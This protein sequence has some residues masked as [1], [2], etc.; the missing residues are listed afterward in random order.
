MS[1]CNS[2]G[3]RALCEYTRGAL[4]QKRSKV[5]IEY[6]GQVRAFMTRFIKPFLTENEMHFKE[7]LGERLMLDSAFPAM[8]TTM[9]KVE[10]VM[11]QAGD[12]QQ[13]VIIKALRETDVKSRVT[14]R[15]EKTRSSS[16]LWR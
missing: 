15:H 10:A 9:G 4:D 8:L 7:V 3:N 14:L 13:L 2:S 5:F 12:E 16:H 6:Q 11:T 1:S